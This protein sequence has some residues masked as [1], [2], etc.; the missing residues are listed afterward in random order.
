MTRAEVS[1]RTDAHL[2]A[3]PPDHRRDERPILVTVVPVVAVVPG[4]RAR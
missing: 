4:D 2:Q 1:Q 3:L